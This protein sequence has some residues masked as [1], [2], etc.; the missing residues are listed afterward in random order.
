MVEVKLDGK[1][2]P[3]RFTMRLLEEFSKMH[4]DGD[5]VKY[6]TDLESSLTLCY[7]GIKYGA[8]GAKMELT[9]EQVE[10]MVDEDPA[11]LQTIMAEF[12]KFSTAFSGKIV[13]PKV[14]S[15]ALVSQS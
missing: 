8:R 9:K 6:G 10:D 3:V 12:G 13:S 2:Y 15:K 1:K 4:S 11:A 14:N 7:L 5:T